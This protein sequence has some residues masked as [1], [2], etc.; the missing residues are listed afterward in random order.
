MS[1][2]EALG[3]GQGRDEEG[4]SQSYTDGSTGKRL[5]Q[6]DLPGDLNCGSASGKREGEVILGKPR[7]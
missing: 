2:R 3:P 6:E 1:T 4:A 5:A 7:R